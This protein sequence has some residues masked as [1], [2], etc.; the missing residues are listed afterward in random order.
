MSMRSFIVLLALTVS[1]TGVVA[2]QCPSIVTIT[3]GQ[4]LAGPPLATRI[5]VRAGT[6]Q[7][8]EAEIMGG[9]WTPSAQQVQTITTAATSVDLSVEWLQEPVAGQLCTSAALLGS[10]SQDRSTPQGSILECRQEAMKWETRIEAAG[11]QR[12]RTGFTVLV[13]MENSGLCYFNREYG[14]YG[15]PIHVG[16]YTTSSTSWR[17]VQ[18]EPCAIES[19]A[20]R[21]FVPATATFPTVQSETWELVEMPPRSCY[22]ES[23][24]IVLRFQASGNAEPQETRFPLSLSP[25]YHG[26]LQLGVAFTDRH[27]HAFGLRPEGDQT[28]VYDRGPADSGPEYNVT[29]VLYGLFHQLASLLPGVESYAGRDIVRENGMLDRIGGVLGVGLT[30]PGRRFTAGFAIEAVRGINVLAVWEF[31]RVKTLADIEPGDAFSG[32]DEDIPVR[33]IWRSSSLVLGVGLDLR[34]VAAL[35]ERK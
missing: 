34:Y 24:D 5:A 9:R 18:F 23:L 28:V 35:F 11:K 33:D 25:R 7:V 1:T 31:A 21:L 13:F 16:I 17:P 22:N 4:E 29:V 2:A 27:E 20:P 8:L 26:T 14:V 6:L 12:R 15:E 19:G 30:D 3:V 10:G 32:D